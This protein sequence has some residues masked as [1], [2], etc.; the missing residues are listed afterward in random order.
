M[1]ADVVDVHD[2]VFV[3]VNTCLI[4]LLLHFIAGTL[5]HKLTIFH[6]PPKIFPGGLPLQASMIHGIETRTQFTEHPIQ[7]SEG[8]SPVSSLST[9]I[10]WPGPIIL[11]SP[12]TKNSSNSKVCRAGLEVASSTRR[13]SAAANHVLGL[14]ASDNG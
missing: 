11:P 14:R 6:K 8:S 10:V 12:Y 5:G 9:V 4:Q 3:L 7:L 1:E 2:L 13:R